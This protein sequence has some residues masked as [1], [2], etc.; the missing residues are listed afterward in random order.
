MALSS[1]GYSVRIKAAS[2]IRS[3]AAISASICFS[4]AGGRSA[5]LKAYEQTDKASA[6]ATIV[7]INTFISGYSATGL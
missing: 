4:S 3:I 6:V 1:G 7:R 2:A 5:A